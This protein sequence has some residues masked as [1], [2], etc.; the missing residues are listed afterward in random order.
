MAKSTF[1]DT[2]RMLSWDGVGD[3]AFREH[4]SQLKFVKMPREYA[5]HVLLKQVS[6]CGD[7]HGRSMR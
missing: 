4:N 3:I 6:F 7:L 2:G 1:R 5:E